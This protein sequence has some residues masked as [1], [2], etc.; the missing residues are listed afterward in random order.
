MVRRDGLEAVFAQAM[1]SVGITCEQLDNNM[2][3]GYPDFKLSYEG[4][5]NIIV[6][7]KSRE[8]ETTLVSHNS[9]V[10]VLSAAILCGNKDT[11]CV[12]LC[13][14][15]VEPNVPS[16]IEACGLLSVVEVSDLA[17]AIIRVY[18]RKLTIEE[19][20]DWFCTPGIATKADLP[21]TL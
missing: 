21:A 17:E 5:P 1:Q 11:F 6:E 10:E 20:F 3:Q 19:L 16:H 18:E 13:S 9:A 12:T 8:S 7:V 4:C 15:G 14:P 2:V